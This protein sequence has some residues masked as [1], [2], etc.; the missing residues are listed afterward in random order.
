MAF[1]INTGPV[2]LG[3]NP[4]VSIAVATVT[5]VFFAFFIN[6]VWA[7]RR[8]PAFSGPDSLV[9]ALGE[10]REELAPE[11][12][13]FVAGAL[14]KATAASPIPA[15][16]AV[17]IVGRQGLELQVALENGQPKEKN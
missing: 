13:V 17:R 8:R 9:G 11:G 5:F 4:F 7:A 12:L 10:A 2:G 6:K 14:W 3:V 16:S 1:L 15:G